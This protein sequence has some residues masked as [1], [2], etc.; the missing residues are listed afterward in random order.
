MLKLLKGEKWTGQ[1]SASTA[2]FTWGWVEW[3]VFFVSHSPL[4]WVFCFIS[5]AG[6]HIYLTSHFILKNKKTGITRGG[7][8]FQNSEIVTFLLPKSNQPIPYGHIFSVKDAWRV[9][10]LF[11]FVLQSCVRADVWRLFKIKNMFDIKLNEPILQDWKTENFFLLSDEEKGKSSRQTR[12]HREHEVLLCVLYRP[13]SQMTW[14][15]A[16]WE[17]L[18][19]RS[20]TFFNILSTA[21]QLRL[22]IRGVKTVVH[23][24]KTKLSCCK[25]TC[26]SQSVKLYDPVSF[27]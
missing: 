13:L 12:Y 10:L 1:K 4:H 27:C 24:V 26:S 5:S 19:P 11:F 16:E 20:N 22:S 23:L 17:T 2:Y 18:E 7:A 14:T 6:K 8:G 15:G 3:L 21:Q 25:D 9:I